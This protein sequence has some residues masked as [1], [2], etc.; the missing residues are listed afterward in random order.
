MH[1]NEILEQ[2]ARII[3]G[4]REDDYGD[5][6]PSFDRIA[7]MWEAYLGVEMSAVDVANMMILLK[8]SRSITSADKLDTWYDICGYAALAGEIATDAAD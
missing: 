8:V 5:A 2:A 1:R 4:D 3:S 7:G 6:A